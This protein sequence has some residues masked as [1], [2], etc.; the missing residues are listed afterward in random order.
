MNRE[1]D[2][3]LVKEV[4]RERVGKIQTPTI[5]IEDVLKRVSEA[6]QIKEKDMAG[7]SR[8]QEIVE[9]RQ[10]AMYLC[11]GIIGSSLANIGVYFG[12][13]DHTTVLHAVKTIERKR[14]ADSRIGDIVK[15][16]KQELTLLSH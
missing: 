4:V 12:G 11:R 15:G 1:I 3:D 14:S 5:S 2:F 16:L 10:I 7:K 6:M 9:A 13:R 8:K